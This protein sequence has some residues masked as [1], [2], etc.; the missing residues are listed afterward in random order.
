MLD[1]GAIEYLR[2]FPK[3]SFFELHG[4]HRAPFVWNLIGGAVEVIIDSFRGAIDII[5]GKPI[6][7]NAVS[8]GY[9]KAHEDCG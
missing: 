4:I 1:H 5:S 6:R 8:I 9:N 2:K 3:Q 7:S